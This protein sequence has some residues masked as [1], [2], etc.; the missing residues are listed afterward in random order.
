MRHDARP[1][2]RRAVIA[3]HQRLDGGLGGAHRVAPLG[4]PGEAEEIASVCV[5]LASDEASYITGETIYCD[6]GRLPQNYPIDVE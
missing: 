4:R 1:P 6:G 2:P 3:Q 5:C